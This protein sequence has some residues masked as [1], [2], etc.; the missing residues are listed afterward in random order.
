M[1]DPFAE[2]RQ[3][4]QR[5]EARLDSPSRADVLDLRHLR[6]REVAARFAR[7]A[8]VVA[9]VVTL[10]FY[11]LIGTSIL[12]YRHIGV[13]TWLALACGTLV[14]VLVLL[15]YAA[16]LSR[17]ISGRARLSRWTVRVVAGVVGAYTLYGLVYLSSMNVKEPALREEYRALHPLLR[18]AT[19][20]LVLADRRLVVTDM[21]RRLEDYEA[22]G[23][24]RFERSLH[25]VQSDGYAH[26]VDLR[27]RGRAEW[28]NALVAAYFK[29]L[30][31]RTLRHVG[32]ADHLHVSLPAP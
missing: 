22:M 24:P 6:G 5:L 21:E 32:T 18:L 13:Q 26:A 11:A 23:L 10:P 17:L 2:Y 19:A 16:S 14:T 25:R 20:T 7:R 4:I 8:A 27:T 29:V 1:M 30:G 3:L 9:L 15:S 12:L 28:R 31:L